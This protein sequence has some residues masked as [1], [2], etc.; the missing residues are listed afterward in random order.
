MLCLLSLQRY[1][2]GWW[3]SIPSSFTAHTLLNSLKAALWRSVLRWRPYFSDW[4]CCD[5]FLLHLKLVQI[6]SRPQGGTRAEPAVSCML[7]GLWL[8]SELPHP[9]LCGLFPECNTVFGAGIF[10][11]T[12]AVRTY[13]QKRAGSS[14]RR[15][16]LMFTD[17]CSHWGSTV[18]MSMRRFK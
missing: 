2:Q 13:T 10:P 15:R 7:T 6:V 18:L 12:E 3:I 8:V 16:G 17:S 14:C 4:T 1:W 9:G 11:G 5:L